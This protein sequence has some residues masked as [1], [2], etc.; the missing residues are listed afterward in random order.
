MQDVVSWSDM[1]I[2]LAELGKSWYFPVCPPWFRV[3][4]ISGI[5]LALH[6]QDGFIDIAYIIDPST[7]LLLARQG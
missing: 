7:G 2:S 4:I 1:I 5:S 6:V 3:N